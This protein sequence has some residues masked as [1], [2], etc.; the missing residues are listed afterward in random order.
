MHLE[1]TRA[2]DFHLTPLTFAAGIALLM[3]LA[4]LSLFLIGCDL[5][6]TLDHIATCPEGQ[7]PVGKVCVPRATNNYVC[8]CTCAT[9]LVVDARVTVVPAQALVFDGP[10]LTT[11]IGVQSQGTPGVV[12]E[13]PLADTNGGPVPFWRVNFDQGPDGYMLETDIAAISLIKDL[14][15]CLPAAINPNVGGTVPHFDPDFINDCKTRVEPN[16][17]GIV[18]VHLPQ[19]S[20]CACQAQE[21]LTEWDTTCDDPCAGSE[22]PTGVCLVTKADPPEPKPDPLAAGFFGPTSICEVSGKADIEIGGESKTTSAQG[23]V[24][25][26]GRPCAAGETCEVGISYQISFADI[27]IP[28]RFHSDPKFVDLGISGAS[29]PAIALGTVLGSLWGGTVPVNATVNSARGRRASLVSQGV[30]GMVGRNIRPLN[31]AVD[32]V[33]KRCLLDGQFLSA[34]TGGAV[35]DDD[36]N[37]VPINIFMTVGGQIDTPAGSSRMVNQP[38][39]ADARANTSADGT[40]E[41][42]SPAGASVTLD[43]SGT[44][45]GDNNLALFAWRSGSP[46][47]TEIGTPSGNPKRTIVQG[48]GE[49]TYYVRATDSRFAA[50]TASVKVKVV[51]T[52]APTVSCNAPA[53]IMPPDKPITFKATATD[54]CGGTSDLVVSE[55]ECFQ[56]ASNGKRVDNKSCKVALQGDAVTISGAGV[57]NTIRWKAGAKDAVGNS[58]Q[59]TCEMTVVNPGKN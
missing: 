23:V 37:E 6:F 54:T 15:V 50:D 34:Q 9:P 56:I 1:A 17:P 48:I 16:L 51:D 2:R 24:R 8:E 49:T 14:D 21:K 12:L 33:S 42:T 4:G 44:T 3:L 40:L 39:R 18:G 45:D 59:T 41:C 43:A 30:V 52:T 36:G 27:E 28:V 20:T 53:T 29:E 25:I 5:I 13:G 58:G 11:A 10:A 35:V 7:T 46:S 26:H 31:L 38:P 22:N 57:G 19:G 32:W 47:G 55:P